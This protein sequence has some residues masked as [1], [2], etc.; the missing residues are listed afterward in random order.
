MATA[1]VTHRMTVV[2]DPGVYFDPVHQVMIVVAIA[3][4][5]G[6]NRSTYG[7]TD[8]GTDD[9]ALATTHFGAECATQ[10]ATNATTNRGITCQIVARTHRETERQR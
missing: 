4:V 2:S 1:I 6:G 10:G 9:R 8:T 7:S 5:I 3:M